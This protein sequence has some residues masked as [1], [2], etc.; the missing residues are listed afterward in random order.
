KHTEPVAARPCVA[1]HMPA[2]RAGDHLIFANHRI[3]VY[4]RSP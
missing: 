4:P 3:A 1:C 2:V